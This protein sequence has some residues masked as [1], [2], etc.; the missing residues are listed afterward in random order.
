[1]KAD[2]NKAERDE[3]KRIY[4]LR[5]KLRGENSDATVEVT[6]GAVIMNGSEVDRFKT[7]TTDF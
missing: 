4:D 7:P 1:M 6:K 3:Y 5:D 2:L